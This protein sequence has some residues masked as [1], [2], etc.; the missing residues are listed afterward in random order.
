MTNR[1]KKINALLQQDLAEILLGSLRE[2]GV[3]NLVLTVTTVRTS[4][5][6]SV[7]KV[8]LSVFPF[9]ESHSVLEGIKSNLGH[10][11]NSLGARV[12]HQLRV[13]PDLLFYLDD[14]LHH[15]EGIEKSLN[16]LSNPL[17]SL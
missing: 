14:S 1:Q 6:L 5:D 8:Y 2:D 11:K 16:D 7:A 9:K 3:R 10:I 15:I 13:V 4:V 12:R 17:D